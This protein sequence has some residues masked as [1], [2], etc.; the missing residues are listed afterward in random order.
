MQVAYYDF[1]LLNIR[2]FSNQETRVSIRPTES[3][4]EVFRILAE[5]TRKYPDTHWEIVGDG[6]WGVHEKR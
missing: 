3:R 1:G 2:D 5:V 6:P 4:H